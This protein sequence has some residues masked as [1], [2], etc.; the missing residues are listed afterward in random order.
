MSNKYSYESLPEAFVGGDIAALSEHIFNIST[1]VS[2][3]DLNFDISFSNLEV[4][5]ALNNDFDI[6]Y[7]RF[8]EDEYNYNGLSIEK[9]SVLDNGNIQFVFNFKDSES[10]NI[11]KTT[12]TPDIQELKTIANRVRESKYDLSPKFDYDK[13]PEGYE[14]VKPNA[15][16]NAEGYSFSM[17]IEET[18]FI[19]EFEKELYLSNLDILRLLDDCHYEF[20]FNE[21]EDIYDY[22]V[23]DNGDFKLYISYDI[24]NPWQDCDFTSMTLKRSLLENHI[25]EIVNKNILKKD[26]KVRSPKI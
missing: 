3:I 19:D 15:I 26:K 17:L 9:C 12:A 20:C 10:D 14:H 7:D 4:I 24:K 8:N 18:R 23:L 25:N 22:K 1:Y 11:Y 2:E 16:W 13:D 21:P 5:M 6:L